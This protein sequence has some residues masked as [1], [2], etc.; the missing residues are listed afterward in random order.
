[1]VD[2]VGSGAL[3]RSDFWRGSAGEGAHDSA[4]S[5]GK[6]RQVRLEKRCIDVVGSR[7]RS[8]ERRTSNFRVDVAGEVVEERVKS[9]VP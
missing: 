1:V 5:I 3:E 9:A 8:V 7:K 6:C 4:G 2:A